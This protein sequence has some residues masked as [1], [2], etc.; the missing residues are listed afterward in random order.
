LTG[1]ALVLRPGALGDT[2]L[3]IP[4]L[5]ALRRS[6]HRIELAAHGGA[7]RLIQA[8]G[9]VDV[10]LAFDDPSLA[11]VFGGGPPPAEMPALIVAWL[12][13]ENSLAIRG[14]P[15]RVVEAPSRPACEDVH[16]ARYLL[17]SVGLEGWD[18]RPLS[19][20]ALRSDEVLV[21]VG[22]GSRAK[23]WPA[24]RFAEVIRGLKT[25]MVPVRLVV[26]EADVLAV[27]SVE[28]RVGMRLPRLAVGLPELASHLAGCRA[29]LG[30]DSGV[31]HLAGMV[32]ART[33]ALFGPT[34]AAVWR[35]LGPRVEVAPFDSMAED[36]VEA[37]LAV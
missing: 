11:W 22:S 28:E 17:E 16:C 18:E 8:A 19:I 3:A 13:A 31:S 23:N 14:L 5:R 2:L 4:A 15:T 33:V 12:S 9:E 36:I 6:H 26:G 35:P 34:P 10:G 30:N 1:R 25:R 21:H 37:L 24:P 7:A 27:A 32:G 29:Y 20:P